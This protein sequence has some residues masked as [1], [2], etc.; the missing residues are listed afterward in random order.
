MEKELAALRQT[1]LLRVP[2]SEYHLVS[3]IQRDGLIH[4]QEYEENDVLLKADIPIRLVS[5][6][7]QY[8]R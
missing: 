4:H 1:M 8:E 7:K 3:E 5:R 6:L 2:Q